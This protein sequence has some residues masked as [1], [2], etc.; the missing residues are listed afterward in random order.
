MDNNTRPQLLSRNLTLEDN[1][2]KIVDN[3]DVRNAILFHVVDFVHKNAD[4]RIIRNTDETIRSLDVQN[5]EDIENLM[6]VLLNGKIEDKIQLRNAIMLVLHQLSSNDLRT[7]IMNVLENND[8]F[9]INSSKRTSDSSTHSRK[10]KDETGYC[11]I[12]KKPGGCSPSTVCFKQITS[13]D[14]DKPLKN[15]ILGSKYFKLWLIK[16]AYAISELYLTQVA[17]VLHDNPYKLRVAEGKLIIELIPDA[18]LQ[19][20]DLDNATNTREINKASI[21]KA[22]M[23]NTLLNNVDE[24]SGNTV[25]NK[26]GVMIPIDFGAIMV[27]TSGLEYTKEDLIE[28]AITEGIERVTRRL[29]T[30]IQYM[31]EKSSYRDFFSRKTVSY[32]EILQRNLSESIEVIT[33]LNERNSLNSKVTP[34]EIEDS[35][36]D[37]FSEERMRRVDVISKDIM[38]DPQVRKDIEIRSALTNFYTTETA[39]RQRQTR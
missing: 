19:D 30:V 1:H 23:I 3:L 11:S 18:I 26:E 17:C 21:V 5:Q 13:R 7:K 10:I 4:V 32:K 6:I 37:I 15:N 34:K 35:L 38:R 27:D 2:E 31:Q 12:Y 39:F 36:N 29:P 25:R 33:G 14:L 9:E 24:K 28:G 20:N 8:K 16:K 22:L